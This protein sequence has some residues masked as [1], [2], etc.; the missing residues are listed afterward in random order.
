LRGEHVGDA[1][2]SAPA[3]STALIGVTA[4]SRAACSI[5][6]GIEEFIQLIEHH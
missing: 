4:L 5:R 1:A 3:F 6:S 2:V